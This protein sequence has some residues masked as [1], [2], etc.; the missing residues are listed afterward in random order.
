[1]L[2]MKH[3]IKRF[4]VPL[5]AFAVAAVFLILTIV[6]AITAQTRAQTTG[7]TD[8]R[9]IT[10][11][12]RGNESVVLTQATTI[13]DALAEAG[14]TIDD[15]DVVEPSIDEELVATDYQVNIYRARPVVVVDGSARTKI[16]TAYQAPAQIAAS[17]GIAFYSE[18]KAEI[19]QSGDIL[20][21]GAGDVMTIDRATA[22]EI[23]LYG[24]TM[25]MRTQAATVGDMLAEKGIKLSTDDRVSTDLSTPITTDLKLRVWREGKQ[26]ITQ[27]EDVEYE[28]EQIQDADQ[29]VGYKSVQT[30]GIKGQKSVTYEVT[31]Q[32]GEEVARTEI[33]SVVIKQPVKQVEVVGTKFTNTF[34][35]SF[36]EALALLRSCEG[37]Y[38]SVSPYGYYGAYQFD[39]GTWGNYKGYSNAAEAPA[40][41]Q[42]EKAWLTYQSRGWQPWPSCSASRGLQDIYR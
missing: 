11:H 26:T 2:I 17:A 15:S 33:A 38:T 41:V 32:N 19:K 30:T 40:S 22:L 37:S 5:A 34:G 36:A 10:I 7:S 31:I 39:I 16:I 14:V 35:G 20:S 9:L 6:M 28:V 42:D 18:D 1:M 8:G 13:G 25:T 29:P 3:I 24:K 12:D 21:D 23:D 27:D 4:H